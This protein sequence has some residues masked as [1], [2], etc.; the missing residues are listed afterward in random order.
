MGNQSTKTEEAILRAGKEEFLT[1]GYEKASLRRITAAASVTTGAIYEYFSGKEALF[2]ALTK[3]AA[4]GLVCLYQESHGEFA[5]L[6]PEEQP[7]ALMTVVDEYMPGMVN[8]V[9]DHFEVFKLILC[10][11]APGASEAF[12]DKLARM[13][14][15]SCFDFM[16]ALKSMGHPVPEMKDSLIHILCRSFFQQIQEFVD[17]DV[18]REEAVSC[19]LM[20][21]KFQHAGWRYILQI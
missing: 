7:E 2:E 14:E 3:E 15:Q 4:D 20:L 8:Y 10:C 9:Y 18:P 21:G 17:H 13:E 12:F 6:P 1:Y 19:A 11:N 16:D 5:A